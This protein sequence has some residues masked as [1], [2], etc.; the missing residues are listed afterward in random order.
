MNIHA[1]IPARG[2]SKGLPGKNITDFCGHPLLAWSIACARC[3][4]AVRGVWVSTDDADIAA[5]ARRYGAEVVDRPPELSGDTASSE[6][7]LIH[8]AGEVEARGFDPTHLMFL[9]ATSPLRE[10]AELN[11]AVETF[12]ARKFDSLFSAAPAEDFCIWRQ[13]GEELE[14]LNFDH[15]ARGRR[16][17]RPD[18]P[19][20]IETGSFYLT[21]LEGLRRTRNRLHGRIGVQEVEPWKAFEIDSADG[22]E[23]C[24]LLFASKLQASIPDPPTK[25]Q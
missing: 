4:A 24:R 7:A 21:D 22:L 20:W 14:S 12:Q 19:L 3:C 11:A 23:L 9:Q 15:R 25:H 6:S 16:Q 1:I 5:V 8:A 18:E 17:D 13:R 10:V 2:G